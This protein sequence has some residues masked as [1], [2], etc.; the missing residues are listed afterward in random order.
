MKK[1]FLILCL[2][3]ATMPMR[4]MDTLTGVFAPDIATLQ[5]NL[6]GDNFAAPIATLG[7]DDR[8]RIQF[9]HL[10]EDREYFRYRLLHCNANWTP[11]GLADSEFVDGFNEGRIE[12]AEFSLGTSTHYVHHSFSLPSDDVR[13][14][15]SG[16]YLV[17]IY[18][19]SNPDSI[20]AQARVMFSENTV[21]VEMDVDTRT[22]V[23]YNR[24]HQQLTLRVDLDREP[25]EDIF[26]DITV[27][28][29]Q[30]KRL[31]NAVALRRP[32][33]ISGHTA[34]YEHQP[35]LIFEAGNEYR[36]FE[37]LNEHIPGMKVDHIEQHDPFY[38][39][40]LEP[41]ASKAFSEYLYDA[42][43]GGRFLIRQSNSSHPETEADY[44]IVHFTLDYPHRDGDMI[45]LDGDMVHRRFDNNS[46]MQYNHATGRY[47]HA[48]LLKQGAYNYRYLYVPAGAKR[49]YT[50]Q[51][52]GD[53]YQTANEYSA[54]VYH[55]RRG[56]RY[57]R[58]IG[59][60][61]IKIQ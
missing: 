7:T 53:K 41:D 32:M 50:A 17:Q 20:V 12:D 5:V 28:L 34:V 39:Y 3:L 57:D 15:I 26:N 4:A 45:F 8:I 14:L 23:D 21:P 43:Q 36:R 51:I 54:E 30:N 49:G 33:R 46:R 59:H 52:E 11:D 22:D 61:H 58:L 13:P 55:R 37:I 60:R 1:Y 18:P 9:D 56:E 16:N 47:E 2:C 29:S 25:V 6:D 40:V 48:L 35:Q 19:E 42:T 27:V 38:H 44:G 10:S 31:D 24:A